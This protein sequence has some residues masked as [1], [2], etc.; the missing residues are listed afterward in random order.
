[1]GNYFTLLNTYNIK[2]RNTHTNTNKNDF[3]MVNLR[4][5]VEEEVWKMCICERIQEVG[6]E[7]W[8]DGFKKTE[9]EKKN[10]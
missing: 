3:G 10:M 6:S 9:R 5:N 2:L 1:M 4:M 7:A 8:K